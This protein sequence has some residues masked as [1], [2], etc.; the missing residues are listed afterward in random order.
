ML[1]CPTDGSILTRD[2]AHAVAFATCTECAGVWFAR[3]ALAHHSSEPVRIPPASRRPRPG[4][5]GGAPDRR[6]RPC[7]ACAAVLTVVRVQGIEIDRCDECGGV[8]LDAGEY[9]AIRAHLAPVRPPA[10][11]SASGA[12]AS[13]PLRSRIYQ[14]GADIGL[15]VAAE[16]TVRAVFRAVAA[17]L[18]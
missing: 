10:V 8:W 11:G 9:D 5:E 12:V 16:L 18:D 1:R 6:P 7:A 2:T 17:L 13:V 14:R 3:E 15:E 4:A